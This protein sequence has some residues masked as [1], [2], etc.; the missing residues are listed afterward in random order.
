[1]QRENTESL[2]LQSSWKMQESRVLPMSCCPSRPPRHRGSQL[3]SCKFPV[4][5]QH[6]ELLLPTFNVKI[7]KP[8]ANL[9][10]LSLRHI[11]RQVPH[12]FTDKSTE[13]QRLSGLPKI[14]QQACVPQTP[15]LAGFVKSFCK[16][17]LRQCYTEAVL[18]LD[19]NSS[20]MLSDGPRRRE[21]TD[22]T[23]KAWVWLPVL[24]EHRL[25]R[26]VRKADFFSPLIN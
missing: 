13:T 18:H 5:G 4:T 20:L 24:D 11:M 25:G 8:C 16:A 17:F 3:P 23:S 14:T 26:R 2:A 21:R 1:M 7:S 15:P 19:A 9:S 10:D 22:W 12:Y 6:L